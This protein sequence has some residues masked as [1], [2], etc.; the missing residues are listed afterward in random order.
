MLQI[1]V[2]LMQMVA[3]EITHPT[4]KIIKFLQDPTKHILLVLNT[5]IQII[6]GLEPQQI[7]FA[8]LL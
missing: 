4:L 2:V 3:Q 7:S 5:E 1:K 8:T 6:G